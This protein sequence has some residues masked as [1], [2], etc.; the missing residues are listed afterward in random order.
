MSISLEPPAFISSSKKFAEYKKDLLRWSRLTSVKPELQAEMVVYRLE[1]HP[2]NIKEK[3]VTQLGDDLEGDVD[4]ITKLLDF[5]E[6]VYGEDDMAD[7][8]DKY[9][10]FKNKKRKKDEPIQAFI[11][12]WENVYCRRRLNARPN[13]PLGDEIDHYLGQGRGVARVTKEEEKQRIYPIGQ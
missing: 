1:G 12:D 2:T 9:V 4:G 10:E 6:T 13:V 3:I 7:A 11:A 8:Y 5:L